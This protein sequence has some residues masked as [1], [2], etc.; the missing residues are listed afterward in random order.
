MKKPVILL[1]VLAVLV[2]FAVVYQ[3]KLD[4][5]KNS[6]TLVGAPSREYLLPELPVGDIRQIRISE[7]GSHLNLKVEGNRWVIQE[8]KGY[9]ASIDA[10]TRAVQSL[11]QLKIIGKNAVGDSAF[12]EL[13]LLAPA[14]GIP[15]EQSGLQV[16]LM[17]GK[18]SVLAAFIAGVSTSTSGGHSSTPSGMM[19]GGG[20]E[21]R[22]VR[23]EKDKNTIWLIN[24]PLMEWEVDPKQW[25]DKNFI[26]IQE[27]KSVLITTPNPVDSWGAERKT[28][29]S[30]FEL[31]GAT[32]AEALDTAKANGLTTLLANGTF[33]DVQPKAEVNPELF[34]GATTVKITTFEGFTYDVKFIIHSE[35][36]GENAEEKCFFTFDVTA[37]LVATRQVP[38]DEKPEDKTKND[39]AFATKLKTL[40][41]KLE[42]EKELSH[43]AF[44][45]SAYNVDVLRMKRGDIL[46]EN[47]TPPTPAV[48][49][50]NNGA[51]PGMGAL[52]P[53]L[54]PAE[55][56]EPAPEAAAP[57]TPAPVEAP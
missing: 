54:Q 15:V 26:N 51:L 8:R 30:A 7:D 24:D 34:K 1:I 2:G 46:R 42:K 12:A 28:I 40:Q 41:T 9:T 44:E 14:E 21:Q 48:P 29:D 27:I 33:I 53:Q 10:I 52:T 37:E 32:S 43:W 23:I 5:K 38:A 57:Q 11:S 56:A 35:G 31:T 39:E 16:E 3:Q 50:L 17:D 47:T 55:P 13:K 19:F 49:N 6:A 4:Q 25:I 18:G 22:Y 45:I 36:A 20:T